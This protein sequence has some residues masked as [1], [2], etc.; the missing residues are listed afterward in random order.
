[1]KAKT[2]FRLA[3]MRAG[4]DQ[5]EAAARAGISQANLSRIES[6]KSKPRH[7]TLLKLAD[8]YGC[9]VDELLGRPPSLFEVQ[10]PR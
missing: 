8:A 9:S 10:L 2:S 7:E 6:S 4:L 3:R 1:M 5:G